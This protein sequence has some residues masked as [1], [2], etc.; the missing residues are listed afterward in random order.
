MIKINQSFNQELFSQ[1][2]TG[3]FALF[4]NSNVLA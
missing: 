4:E 3:A 1:T 2:T